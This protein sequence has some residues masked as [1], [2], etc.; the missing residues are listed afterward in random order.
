M[1]TAN[2]FKINVVT[3]NAEPRA[4]AESVFTLSNSWSP[5]KGSNCTVNVVTGQVD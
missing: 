3:N 5:V 4:K 2:K 1:R